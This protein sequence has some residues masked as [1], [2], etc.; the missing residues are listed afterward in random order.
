MSSPDPRPGARI[1]NPDLLRRLHLEWD[2]CE[3]CGASGTRL[4]LHHV[5][6]HPRDDV[7]ENLVMLCGDGVRGCHGKIESND[8]ETLQELALVLLMDRSD[9]V[10]HLKWRLG[11]EAAREWLR[12]HLLGHGK[13]G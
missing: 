3:I 9:V 13:Y 12:R 4:S 11:D 7:R 6:K 8:P 5:L 10:G 2:C 1:R